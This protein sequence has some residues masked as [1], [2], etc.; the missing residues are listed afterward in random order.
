MNM[1]FILELFKLL[2]AGAPC[3]GRQPIP[4]RAHWLQR[5]RLLLRRT[6][7]QFPLS[8]ILR[9]RVRLFTF[10]ASAIS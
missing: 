2:D 10:A 9:P 8:Q 6:L 4:I 1:F 7:W 3:H 5:V